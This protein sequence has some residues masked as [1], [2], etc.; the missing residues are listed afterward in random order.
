MRYTTKTEYGLVCLVYMAKKGGVLHPI[1]VKEMVRN[2]RY[3]IPY[4]EKILQKLRAAGIVDSQAGSHGGYTLAKPPSEISFKDIIE[5]LEGHTFEAFCEPEVRSDIVCTH[6]PACGVRPIWEK[7]K[8]ILDN[9]YS[10]VTLDKLASSF[11]ATPSHTTS[12][13]E[14]GAAA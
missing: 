10:T 8:E 4:I 14:G 7:T 1:T 13:K 5:A 11:Y 3:S 9:Y 6:F 2:E 12:F